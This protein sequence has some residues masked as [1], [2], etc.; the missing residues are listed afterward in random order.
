M[1]EW[2]VSFEWQQITILSH[3]TKVTT[4]R[5]SIINIDP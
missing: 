4:L 1:F 2:L 5:V 3:K